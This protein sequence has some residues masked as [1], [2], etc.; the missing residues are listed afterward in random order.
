MYCQ[1]RFWTYLVIEP[2]RDKFPIY[3]FE[4]SGRRDVAKNFETG[5]LLQIELPTTRSTLSLKSDT[6]E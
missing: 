5:G 2:S 6:V 3:W 4:M 1:N